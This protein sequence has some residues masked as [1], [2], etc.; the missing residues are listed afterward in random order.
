M[1]PWLI[2]SALAA[3]AYLPLARVIAPLEPR[4]DQACIYRLEVE[5]GYRLP[6]PTPN[7]RYASLMKQLYVGGNEFPI[8]TGNQMRLVREMAKVTGRREVAVGYQRDGQPLPSS[9]SS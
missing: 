6:D 7:E 3:V 5:L 9:D 8:P 2:A 1:I 4:A